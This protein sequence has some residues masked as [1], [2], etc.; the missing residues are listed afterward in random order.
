M[1]AAMPRGTATRMAPR[2]TR[3][4]PK[5]MARAPNSGGLAA[6][7]PG[8]AG[9]KLLQAAQ[10]EEGDGV[11]G[12]IEDDQQHGHQRQGGGQQQEAFEK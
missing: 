7:E 3:P 6:G 2:V 4:L 1:A 10:L 9:E 11:A 5:K 12:D 8:R